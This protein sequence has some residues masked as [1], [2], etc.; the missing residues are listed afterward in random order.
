MSV[1]GAVTPEGGTVN[2]DDVN[3][4]KHGMTL[5][6]SYTHGTSAATKTV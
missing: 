6:P 4:L 5:K 2:A 3:G 1:M